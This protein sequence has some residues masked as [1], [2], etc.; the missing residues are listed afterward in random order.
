MLEITPLSY[1]ISR[2]YHI[3]IHIVFPIYIYIYIYHVAF[4]CAAQ[5]VH[6]STTPLY[7][8]NI[9]KACYRIPSEYTTATLF[10]SRPAQE[11]RLINLIPE[12]GACID[13]TERGRDLYIAIARVTVYKYI[14]VCM[15]S[16]N[17]RAMTTHFIKHYRWNSYFC[18]DRSPMVQRRRRP[19]I[20]YLNLQLNKHT[21]GQT[22]SSDRSH[23]LATSMQLASTCLTALW[24]SYHNA[25]LD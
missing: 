11:I 1:F 5:W 23:R 10:V 17:D 21:D 16:H 12:I 20:V 19:Q 2:S 14:Y 15:Q 4:K 24:A 13:N 25:L 18:S 9:F 6:W 8:N 22:L 3:F 7:E